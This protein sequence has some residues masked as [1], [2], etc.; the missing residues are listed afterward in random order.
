M[1]TDEG[2]VKVLDFGLAKL[3][4]RPE[5]SPDSTTVTAGTVTEEGTAIGTASYMSPEQAEGRKLDARSDIFSFGAVLYEMVTGRRPFRGD[6]TM[7]ILAKVLNEDP[8][9]PAQLATSVPSDLEKII[10]RCLRKDSARRYQ[11]MADLKVALEDVNGESST[12]ARAQP[13]RVPIGRRWLATIVISMLLVAAFVSW[14]NMRTPDSTEPLRA[15]PLITQPGVQRYPSISPDGNHVAFTWTGLKRDNPDVY[16]QQI[17][18]GSP[19]RLTTDPGN[20][21]NPVWSPDGRWIAFLRRQSDSEVSE[22]WLIPPFAGTGRK[23]SEIRVRDS[24]GM[25]PP[26]LCWCPDGSCLVAT[27][28]PGEGKLDAL[29]VISQETGQKRQLTNP[30]PPS[31]GDTNPTVSPDSNWLVFRRPAGG[32][33]TGKLYALRLAKGLT[34]V[35]EPQPLTPAGLDPI[36]PT[37][38]PNSRQIMFSARGS[39][40]RLLVPGGNTP[41][42]IPFVGDDGLMP[43][44]SRPQPERPSR[45]VY[46]RS[47]TDTNLWRVDTSAPGAPAPAPPVQAVASTRRD[48]MPQLSPDGRRVAF[49]S[50][51]SGE[52]EIWVTELD[53]SNPSQLTFMRAVAAGYPHWSPDGER[54]VFHSSVEGQWE[55]FAIPAGG[56]KPINLT[57]NPASDYFP[58]F[59]SDGQWI[60]FNSTRT[61]QPRI[62]KMPASGGAAVPVLNRTGEAPQESPDGAWLYFVESIAG[63]SPLWRSPSAGECPVKV[64]ENVPSR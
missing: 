46:V 34:G 62:W 24:F 8:T 43:V 57:S 2:R 12:A 11:T 23:L 19:L 5:P 56:G 4:E 17:G 33:Y 18:A 55:V 22:V 41:S 32:L 42:R 21:Y 6:S 31:G 30:Q 44:V 58:S 47:F 63:S 49:T 3:T 54:I 50:D 64:V 13:W 9:P 29:F 20:D 40:W 14:R 52:F 48:S 61:G 15:V 27:D 10:L 39:L 38:M 35:G 60:Y 25:I 16:V 28:S 1:V 36:F 53:G 37:W 7:S 45:L 26:H 59:S 51:R